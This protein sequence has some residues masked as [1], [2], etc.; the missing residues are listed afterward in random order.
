MKIVILKEIKNLG[1]QGQVKEVSAGYANNFLIP[2]GL[3]RPATDKV[4]AEI[5]KQ[6]T[7]RRK[8]QVSQLARNKEVIQ[9]INGLT[10][11]LKVK[12]DDRGNLYGSVSPD[13]I[14]QRLNKKGLVVDKSKIKLPENIKK[15]GNYQINLQLDQE[16]KADLR[17][18]V[19]A[20]K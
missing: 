15:L 18:I 20:E 19:E 3:A 7:A 11:G 6:V 12:A 13:Q 8:K 17:L 5:Q 16:N 4:L 9:K 10:I 2:K 14:V 1:R